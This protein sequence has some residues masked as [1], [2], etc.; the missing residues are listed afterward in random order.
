MKSIASNVYVS[1]EY[2]YVNVG[3]IVGPAGVVAVDAPTLPGDAWAW[4]QQISELTGRPIVYTALTDAHPHRLLCAS[5]LGAPI[6]ASRAAYEHAAEYSRGFWRNVIR[7]LRRDHPEQGDALK[8]LDPALPGLLFTETLT[9]HK[10]GAEVTMERIEGAAPGSSWV[11]VQDARILF[12]G[13]TLVV[14]R[15]PV[16]EECPDTKAWLDT[17]TL[18]RRPYLSDVTLVPG[19]GAM[20]DQS[21]TEPMS[22]Y[23][24]LA[25]RRVRSLHRRG[26]PREE[27]ADAVDELLSMFSLPEERRSRFRRRARNGLKQVYDELASDHDSE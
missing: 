17:L 24:R 11:K 22:E 9:L 20:G 2:P 18:L 1:T 8:G 26:R 10:G 15:P 14:G 21:T 6:A 19:R 5:L 13:D 23:I 3:C 7:R 25:R 27:V 4:R 16:M 12:L